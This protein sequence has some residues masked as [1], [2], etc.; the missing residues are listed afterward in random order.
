MLMYY[1]LKCRKN[2]ESKNPSVARTKNRRITLLSKY[3][4]CDCNIK[5]NQIGKKITNQNHDECIT[6]QEFNIK[7]TT[8]KCRNCDNKLKDVTS[9]KKWIKWRSKKS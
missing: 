1:C 4:V 8:T 3:A 5:I 2:T 7:I 9:K 6:T